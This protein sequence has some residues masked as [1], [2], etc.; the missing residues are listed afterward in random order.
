[1]ERQNHQID[2]IDKEKELVSNDL[3]NSV[4]I[5]EEICMMNRSMAIQKVDL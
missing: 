3:L 1:L 2:V 5:K 4:V